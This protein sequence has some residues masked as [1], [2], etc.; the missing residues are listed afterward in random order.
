MSP[1]TTLLDR[2]AALERLDGDE[3]LLAEIVAIFLEDA[4]RLFLALK[5]ARLDRDHKTSERQAHSLKGASANVGAVMLQEICLRAEA[6]ARAGE[7]AVLE[8][9]LPELETTLHSTLDALGN[10]GP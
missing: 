2:D 10:E 6:A 1:S 3:E 9:L 5:Q 4:P 8:E 7:W